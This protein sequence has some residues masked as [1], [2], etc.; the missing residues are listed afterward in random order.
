[1][2]GCG[3]FSAE[4]G[5]NGPLRVHKNENFFGFDF[6][7]CTISL[8]VMLKYL[9]FVNFFLIEP[10]WGEVRLFRIVIRL[11][12][13]TKKCQARQFF[14]YIIYDPFIFAKNC[15][16]SK[17]DPLTVPGMTLCVDL[18]QKCQHLFCFV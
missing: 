12:G 14:I 4:F 10:M 18:G 3:A 8:L 11:R 15:F 17:F 9:G 7:F 2:S 13:T 6:E 1:M 16:F 5:D